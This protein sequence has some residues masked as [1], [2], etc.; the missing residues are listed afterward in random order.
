MEKEV[1]LFNLILLY[2]TH[3]VSELRS[4]VIGMWFVLEYP[5]VATL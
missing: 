3:R 2:I 1:D 4:T 5:E